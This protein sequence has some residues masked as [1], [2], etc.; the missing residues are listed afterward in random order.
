MSISP[1]G[2]M[3]FINQNSSVAS[4]KIADAQAKNDFVNVANG[5]VASENDKEMKSVRP[6]E[7]TYKIDPKNEHEK[8]HSQ[9]EEH[10]H[11][12]Q[13][14]EALKKKEKEQQQKEEENSPQILDITV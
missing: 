6:A 8:H 7:A 14:K 3:I 2:N 9:D 4:T 10:E 12:E 13:M 5:I 11:E 1:V